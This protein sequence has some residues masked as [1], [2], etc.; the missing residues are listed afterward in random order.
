MLEDGVGIMIDDVEELVSVIP[1]LD[2]NVGV[3]VFHYSIL[4]VLQNRQIWMTTKGEPS[5]FH[6]YCYKID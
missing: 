5:E 3:V 4:L 6:Q 2:V 1:L